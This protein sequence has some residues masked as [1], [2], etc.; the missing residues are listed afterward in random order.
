VEWK[1]NNEE[2]DEVKETEN[3]KRSGKNKNEELHEIKETEN[4][5]RS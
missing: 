1:I 5:E 3:E 2:L 4:E